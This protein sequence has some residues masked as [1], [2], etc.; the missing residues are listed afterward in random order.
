MHLVMLELCGYDSGY[1]FAFI[2][3]ALHG[4]ESH[5]SDN[6]VMLNATR[7]TALDLKAD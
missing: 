4:F 2:R 5:S 6:L 1:K 7:G 3:S